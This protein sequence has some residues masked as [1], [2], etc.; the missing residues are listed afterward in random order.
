MSLIKRPR[1]VSQ[2]AKL[3]LA[4]A[5]GLMLAG[6]GCGT[7]VRP[8]Y[9]AD[10][11]LASRLDTDAD[12]DGLV[13]SRTYM[14]AGRL[15]RHELDVTGDGRVDRWEYYRPDGTLA[16]LGT[17]SAFDG[18]EDTWVVQDGTT[19]HVEVSTR[20]DGFIDRRETQ[21]SGVL[22]RSEQDINFDG[23][24]DQWA[25]YDNG[26]VR[27]LRID[28][29]LTAGR[30]DRRLLYGPDGALRGIEEDPDGDGKFAPLAA[31]VRP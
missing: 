13:E 8:V 18:I 30:P 16:R 22:Q 26:R 1:S 15:A 31:P 14:V 25:F 7:A 4:A 28:T 21:E 20:R 6:T 12:R 10:S 5:A 11:R 3:Y 17:S 19:T 29:G 24:P 2:G 27:E 23:Q 9:D